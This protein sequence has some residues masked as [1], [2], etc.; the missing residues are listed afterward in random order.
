MEYIVVDFEWNQSSYGKG[1]GK[2]NLPFEIIEI[3]A[4]KLDE[5]RHIIDTFEAV[6]HPKFIKN[7]II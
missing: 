1:T 6:I 2:K 4:V 3:G 5:D 7:Y